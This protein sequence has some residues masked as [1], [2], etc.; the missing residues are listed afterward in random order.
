MEDICRTNI[1]KD[2]GVV[3][4]SDLQYNYSVHNINLIEFIIEQ[5]SEY[6][7][8]LPEFDIKSFSNTR[9]FTIPLLEKSNA[10]LHSVLFH[11]IG[12]HHH[13]IFDTLIGVERYNKVLNEVFNDRKPEE[14]SDDDLFTYS[15][16]FEILKGAVREIYSDIYAYEFCGLSIIFAL[17]FFQQKYPVLVLPDVHTNFYPPM[18]YRIRTL[19][20][21]FENDKDSEIIK[22][23]DDTNPYH[24]AIKKELNNI[25][26]FLSEKDDLLELN[27]KPEI[28]LAYKALDKLIPEIVSDATLRVNPKFIY[29][30]SHPK[31]FN[32]FQEGIPPCEIND[33]PQS[34]VD[35]LLSGWAAY[36]HILYDDSLSLDL[37]I[38]KINFINTLIL[39]SITQTSLLKKFQE[40]KD[41]HSR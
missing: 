28:S 17:R 10:I 25:T 19:F 36:F 26:S 6:F 34:L 24:N 21:I 15:K 1:E 41:A 37:K 9:I 8:K 27:S 29:S 12:H 39:K 20:K 7:G 14:F 16:S 2:I 11:E 40:S 31:L 18:K 38:T 3:L 4:K 23:G 13:A 35:I 32:K 22:N 33:K 30:E 5:L